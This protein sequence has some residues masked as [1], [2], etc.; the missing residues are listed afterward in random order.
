MNLNPPTEY[1]LLVFWVGL[2]VIL[3]TARALGALMQRVGQPAVVGELA[4]GLL[5]GPSLL[6]RVA[7]GAFEWLFP[8]DDVQTAMLFTV[9]WLG[10]LLLLVA[11]GFET[12]LGLIGRLGRAA[13][14]VSTGSLL[15]PALAGFAVGWF[16]PAAFLGLDTERYI[17]ALFI[18]AALSISSLPVIAKILSEMGLMRRNFGQLTLA[19]GM[20]N[21][22]VGWIALGFIA[23]LAQ[24]GGVK[25]D[26]LAITLGGLVIFFVLAFTVGQRAVDAGLRRVRA[27]GDDP[28]AG[29]TVI[30]VTALT[31][32]VITQWLH[33]EAVLGAFVAGV[34]IARSR[35]GDHGLIRPLETMTAAIFAPVFFATAGLRV[36]LGL[37]ADTE[38]L[39]WAVVV[40][41]A[42][43]ASKFVGSILGAQLSGLPSREGAALGVGLN[44]RGALEIVIATV[45]LSLGVL[46]ERSYT[47]IVLMAMATS[48]LAP[49][50]LRRVLAGW[51]GDADERRR[52]D[53]E[54]QLDANMIVTGGRVLLPTTGGVSSIV[55]AQIV[56][57]V[58]PTVTHV[59]LITVGHSE[60]DLEAV[61]NTLPGRSVGHLHVDDH[62]MEG[63]SVTEAILAES[64]LGYDAIVIG[65][66]TD[67]SLP[68]LV[69]P[70]VDEIANRASIPTV[71]VRRPSA[72]GLPW[73]FSRALVP[74]SGSQASR[75]AQEIGAYLS[76]NIGTLLHQLHVATGNSTRINELL[77]D[78][79][80]RPSAV[81]HIVNR[82]G[83]FAARLGANQITIV[84]AGDNAGEHI[85]KTG[86]E[87]N[88]DIVILSGTSR[89]GGG[90]LFLGHTIHHVLENIDTTV[91]I[92]ITPG[93]R[94]QQPDQHDELVAASV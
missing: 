13:T 43:S 17:F 53:L 16:I 24:A 66:A 65:S 93:H 87:L 54:A 80:P 42:A 57:L 6:G 74:L 34:V 9:G 49:P 21:D 58:W 39:L 62:P 59:E 41:A 32:G 79:A 20:A 3:V 28:L 94:D 12:D 50:L 89:T 36:D 63:T 10:V 33:V 52:M 4:A 72:S 7:P 64:R 45:G 35:F 86:R 67:R 25:L 91:V 40:L 5:L 31:F 90:D 27:G 30:L 8:A 26:K 37:L 61:K 51:E 55:A 44:A 11:T 76:A 38:T 29:L 83:D 71:V 15:V 69:S 60:V 88:A 84:E 81:R 70:L 56:G 22:V 1:Q 82:A 19:A 77:A 14:L 92:A 47:V 48:M 78:H 46:N 68:H 2:L 75:G 18:A 73:A 85:V 23:G